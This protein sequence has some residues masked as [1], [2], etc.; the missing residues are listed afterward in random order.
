MTKLKTATFLVLVLT[1]SSVA[2][3]AAGAAVQRISTE[4]QAE[5]WRGKRARRSVTAL[6]KCRKRT[7]RRMRIDV[8]LPE[9]I[10]SRLDGRLEVRITWRSTRQDLDLYLI[11]DGAVVGSSRRRGTSSERILIPEPEPGRYKAVIVPRKSA[12]L[13][14]RGSARLTGLEAAIPASIDR[15]CRAD[16]TTKILSWVASV[17]DNTRLVFPA[18]ACYRIDGSLKFVDRRGLTFEGNGTTFQA[19]AEGNQ[20]RRHLWF[21]GGAR[22]TVRDLTIRGANPN[23]GTGDA[24]YREERAFQHGLAFH[25]VTR[26]LVERVQVYDVYGDFVYLGQDVRT[27]PFRP[28]SWIT[29]Q[30]SHFE[31]NGRQGIGIGFAE[32]VTIRR[33]YLGEVRRATF[34][35]EPSGT[36]GRI[37]RINIV[38]NT[39]GPGRLLWLANAGESY[40]VGDIRIAG[41]VMTTRA[42]GSILRVATPEGGIRGPFLIEGNTFRVGGSPWAAFHF[43]RVRGVTV[44]NNQ[45]LFQ[46]EKEMVAVAAYGSRSIVVTSNEFTGA[47]TALDCVDSTD[48]RGSGNTT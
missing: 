37:R 39:T 25:G 6:S 44:R 10:W 30:D 24:A 47:K 16:V 14:Y 38:D 7:C 12:R 9:G 4:D 27:K 32:D 46:P 20:D 42:S 13:R 5:T 43:R 23:A 8:S 18:Q 34:D 33:T 31:R 48:C 26:A 1:A 21:V 41:N 28:A 15:A 19:V 40:N 29:I 17:P 22:L 11:R 45:V 3:D 2:V 36:A 35:L